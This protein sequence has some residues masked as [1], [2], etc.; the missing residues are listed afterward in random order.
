MCFGA[1]P[2]SILCCVPLIEFVPFPFCKMGYVGRLLY[3]C[4][5]LILCE[6]YIA[7]QL[8]VDSTVATEFGLLIYFDLFVGD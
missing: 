8:F 5:F 2:L 6:Y 1:W 7:G 4:C 3:R